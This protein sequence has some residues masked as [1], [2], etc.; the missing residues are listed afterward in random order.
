VVVPEEGAIA[1]AR[2]VAFESLAAL[3]CAV[4]TGIGAVTSAARVPDGAVVAVIGAGGVGLNVVQGAAIAGCSRIIAADRQAGPLELATAMGATD[5]VQANGDPTD[6]ILARTAGR[7]ADFVFDTVGTADTLSQAIAAV[8]KGGTVVLTGLSRIDGQGSVPMFP[9]VMQEKR[10]IGSVYGS[11][12]PHRDIPRLV[13]LHQEGRLK[14]RE[15]A[16][17][18]YSLAEI[19]EALAALAAGEG[20]RGIV[21]MAIA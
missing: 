14:L 15:I 8:C 11:G 1:V 20:G 6:D 13:S 17:R 5:I 7:G 18:T 3:G 9:F 10:L 2:D 19:N 21:R 16:A 4:V 12:D